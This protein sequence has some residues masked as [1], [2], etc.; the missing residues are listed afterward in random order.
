MYSVKQLAQLA[1]VSVRTLHYYVDPYITNTIQPFFIWVTVNS[2]GWLQILTY[3][4]AATLHGQRFPRAE[5]IIVGA[6]IA[7]SV[8]SLI[9]NVTV[10]WYSNFLPLFYVFQFCIS[11]AAIA[12]T[13]IGAF[14]SNSTIAKALAFMLWLFLLFGVHDWLLQSWYIDL[15]SIFLIHLTIQCFKFLPRRFGF[16]ETGNVEEE[17]SMYTTPNN[18]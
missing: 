4:F 17:V 14:R 18:S 5:R 16:L 13:T 2:L 8:V 3:F 9:V 6:T 11:I 7:V 15:E 10:P 1:G 12:L